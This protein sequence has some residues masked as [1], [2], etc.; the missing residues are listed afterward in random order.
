[1]ALF[2]NYDYVIMTCLSTVGGM[3]YYFMNIIF[4]QMVATIFTADVVEGG[5]LSCTVGG[6]AC[7]GYFIG[8]WIAVPGGHM[9]Y[10]LMFA[11]AGLCAFVGGVA[12]AVES[13][14]TASALATCGGIM[15]GLL[16]IMASTV[17]QE[18]FAPLNRNKMV[19]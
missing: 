6:G 13:Q 12:G 17:S 3:V 11:A 1:M 14:A 15:V 7:A 16:E 19:K 18:R 8:S 10:K 9:K 2:R 4:P 5:L